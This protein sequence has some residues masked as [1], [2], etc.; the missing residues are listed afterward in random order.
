M[1]VG[2]DDPFFC[3]IANEA[4]SFSVA[5]SSGFFGRSDPKGLG[6]RVQGSGLRV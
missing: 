2:V 5:V 3:L 1:G 4:R 6:F